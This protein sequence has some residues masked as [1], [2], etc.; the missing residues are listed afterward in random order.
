[1]TDNPLRNATATF[2]AAALLAMAIGAGPALAGDDAGGVGVPS[3]EAPSS[4]GTFPVRAR[5]TYGDGLGAGRNH[6]G[7]DLMA[8]CGKPVVAAQAGRVRIKDYQASGA[9]NFVVIKGADSD[10]DYVY[11]HMLPGLDV[12]EGD[13][14]EVGDPIGQVGST[15]RSS[16]CH[17]HFEMWTAP[18][19]YLGG[20]VADPTPQLKRWDRSS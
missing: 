2:A 18:G 8:K 6:Q 3:S 15:G 4:E 20:D 13:R 19:W 14:V 16:A 10:F 1:M 9:G 12:A 7:Q 17:L 11:M 5:H